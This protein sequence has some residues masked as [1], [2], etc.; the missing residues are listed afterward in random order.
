MDDEQKEAIIPIVSV[1]QPRVQR[2]GVRWVSCCLETD[3]NFLIYFSQ[4]FFSFCV[5]GFCSMM[6]VN[7]DGHCEKSSPYIGII[8]FLLGKLLSA[9]S[10][11]SQ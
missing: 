11:S 10:D 1:Q 5:L 7:A 6:L 9:V 3:K 2:N 8:S 4:L